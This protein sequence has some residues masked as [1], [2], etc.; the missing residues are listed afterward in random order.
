MS[1]FLSTA[2]ALAFAFRLACPSLAVA[3]DDKPIETTPPA[4][5]AALPPLPF[6][7]LDGNA[8]SLADFKGKVMVLNLWATWCAP[9][10]KEMPSLAALQSA[11]PKDQVVV[12][13]L[14]IDRGTDDKVKQFI[15]DEGLQSLA[16]YRDAKMAIPRTL[17]LPGI[18][19]TLLIDRNGDEAARILGERDWSSSQ[20]KT[21]IQT[22]VDEKPAG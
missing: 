4:S 18:P 9:C 8:A 7:G 17:N 22:L 16:V 20:A 6:K 21:A 2:V 11:F 14:S 13:A 15:A 19:A 10:K 12:V 5:R 1:R 3:Q